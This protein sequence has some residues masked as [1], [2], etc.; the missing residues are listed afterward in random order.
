MLSQQSLKQFPVPYH[1]GNLA[2]TSILE[3]FEMK[4]KP[5]WQMSHCFTQLK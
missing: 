3:T 4:L 1:Q 2:E 5:Q